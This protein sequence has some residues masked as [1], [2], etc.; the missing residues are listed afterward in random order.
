MA[1]PRPTIDVIIVTT[2]KRELVLSC[3]EH[4]H[5]QTVPH[6]VFA[7]DNANNE[8]GTSDAIRQLYPEVTL[9][10]LEE[11]IGFGNAVNRLVA[12]GNSEMVVLAN[13]DMDVEPRFLEHMASPFDDPG[14]GMVA[15]MTLQPGGGE[16]VDGFGIEVDSTL[17]AFNRLRHRSPADVPG[18]LLG[19]SGGAGAYRRSAWEEAGGFEPAFFV[20][21]E[22]QDLA[23]RLRLAGWKAAGAPRARGVHLGGA[24]TGT[25]SKFQRWNAGFGRGFLLRRFGVLRTR[26]APRALLVELLTVLAGAWRGRT[27]VPLTARIAGWRAAKDE[28]RFEYPGEY[29][30]HSINLS[31]TIRRLRHER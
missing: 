28:P 14:V 8:D 3:L 11:N 10:T 9:V 31:K 16:L 17:V 30:N 22:D 19:P 4:L 5:R 7:A 24:T 12:M 27:I 18:L 2:N 20:Y 25:D 15:G 21:A 26:Y 29:V 23:L 13:D 1:S 6:N